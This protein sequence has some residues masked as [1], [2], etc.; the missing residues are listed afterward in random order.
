M[1]TEIMGQTQ[2][3]CH[4][5]TAHLGSR[6]TDFA[7]ELGR[8]FDNEHPHIWPFPFEHKR[9]R[10][11]GKRAPDDHDIVFEVHRNPENGLCQSQ[12]QSVPLGFHWLD[13]VSPNER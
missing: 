5:T 2:N 12:T 13:G 9:G 1:M 10:G 8:F 4:I 7:I 11:T 6:F 3:F